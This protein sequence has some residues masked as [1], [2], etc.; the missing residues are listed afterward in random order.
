MDPL[1]D[2]S[3]KSGDL[4]KSVEH[5]LTVTDLHS[6]TKARLVDLRDSIHRALD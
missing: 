4:L 6:D 3:R 5:A 2:V 1:S